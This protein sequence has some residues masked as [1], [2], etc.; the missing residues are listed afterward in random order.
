M[1]ITNRDLITIYQCVNKILASA[2]AKKEVPGSGKIV[3]GLTKMSNKMKPMIQQL[4][5]EEQDYRKTMEDAK[6]EA[7]SKGEPITDILRSFIQDQEEMLETLQ[8]LELFKI[9]IESTHIIQKYLDNE[10]HT[11]VLYNLLTTE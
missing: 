1:K 7:E 10:E 4:A 11:K 6:K 3:Y 5:Q 2:D 8:E 9:D